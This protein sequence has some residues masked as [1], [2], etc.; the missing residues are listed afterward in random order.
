MGGVSTW[1]SLVGTLVLGVEGA[2]R[3]E[4]LEEATRAWVLPSHL[5]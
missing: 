3:S 5:P 1:P 4:G 2:A